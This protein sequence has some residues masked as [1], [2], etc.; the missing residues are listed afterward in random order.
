MSRNPNVTAQYVNIPNTLTGN[1]R[2]YILQG[3]TPNDT[4]LDFSQEQRGIIPRGDLSTYDWPVYP[5]PQTEGL[6][7]ETDL[8]FF[9]MKSPSFDLWVEK[10]KVCL[11]QASTYGCVKI[12]VWDFGDSLLN[13]PINIVNVDVGQTSD[14]NCPL[15]IVAEEKL[16]SNALSR[17]DLYMVNTGQIC[18]TE[19][20]DYTISANSIIRM[21]I[22]YA[23]GN[24][25]GLKAFIVGW[26]L[27]CD[28]TV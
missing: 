11:H 25:Y 4:K 15:T 17:T 3:S 16:V 5:N 28:T 27:E 10:I 20:F 9:E 23:N 2:K 24:G 1:W 21:G 6:E 12:N 22:Q 26:G 14:L 18:V 19:P 13:N 8:V 7:Y